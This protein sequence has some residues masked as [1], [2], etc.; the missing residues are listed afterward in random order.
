LSQSRPKE[1]RGSVI[2]FDMKQ[3]TLVNFLCGNSLWYQNLPTSL[4]WAES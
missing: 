4:S 1:I 2:V 3:N